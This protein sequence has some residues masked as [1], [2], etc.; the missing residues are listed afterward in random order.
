MTVRD[1]RNVFVVVFVFLFVN[2]LSVGLYAQTAQ[3][4]IKIAVVDVDKLIVASKAAKSV[5]KQF[6]EK[7]NKFVEHVKEQEDKFRAEQKG[8]EKQRSE[9]SK[10]DFY[11]TAQD[12]EKRRINAQNKLQKERA[13]L[14]QSYSKA[15]SKLTHTIADVCQEIADEQEIDLIITRETIIIGNKKLDI[16]SDVMERMNKK[17][18]SLSLE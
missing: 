18:P 17:L 7:R 8:I 10:E 13:S 16:T 5:N 14:D 6:D 9:L 15:M 12:F 3:A 11:K 4:E 2:G 1:I